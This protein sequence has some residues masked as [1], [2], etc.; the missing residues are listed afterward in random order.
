MEILS[1][2]KRKSPKDASRQQP[3]R[4]DTLF[5]LLRRLRGEVTKLNSDVS[6]LKRDVNRIERSFNRQR[7]VEVSASNAPF[8]WKKD[9]KETEE[10]I[11]PWLRSLTQ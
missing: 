9:N 5:A 8:D 11:P 1:K 7:E 10:E 4:S 6:A 2:L 3:I